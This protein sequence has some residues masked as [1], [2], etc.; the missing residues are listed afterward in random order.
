MIQFKDLSLVYP[1]GTQG[2][3]DVN[4]TINEPRIR[5]YRRPFRSW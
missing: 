3:K 2:L 1:N 5:C 4:V